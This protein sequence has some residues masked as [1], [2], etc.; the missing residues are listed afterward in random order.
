MIRVD[1]TPNGFPHNWSIS[2]PGPNCDVAIATA[3]TGPTESFFTISD[4]PAGSYQ[5]C[6]VAA[7]CTMAPVPFEVEELE[8]L[9]LEASGVQHVLCFGEATGSVMLTAS[10][11][12][13]P[14]TIT[15]GSDPVNGNTATYGDLPAGTYFY[16]V[17]DSKGCS[18]SIPVT[19]NQPNLIFY[20]QL[21]LQNALCA[22]SA[23]GSIA[24]RP[25]GG[26]GSY[27]VQWRPLGG[28]YTLIALSGGQ[29][30]LSDIGAGSYQ[31]SIED[32]NNCRQEFTFSISEP[33]ALDLVLSDTTHISCFGADD[34][35][36][37]ANGSGGTGDLSYAIDGGSFGSNPLFTN[38]SPGIHTMHVRDENNCELTRNFIILEPTPL[39]GAVDVVNVQCYGADN[40]TITINATGGTAPYRYRLGPAISQVSNVFDGLAPDLYDLVI[41]DANGCTFPINNVLVDEPD[42]LM[43]STVQLTE[44]TCQSGGSAMVSYSGGTPPYS[45][46]WDQDTTIDMDVA[47]D[48]A[49]GLHTVV[50]TDAQGCVIQDEIEITTL[51]VP[52]I[53]IVEIESP[54]C[55]EDN[56]SI[57]ID[58]RGNTLTPFTYTID[59]D[60]MPDGNFTDL[61]AGS[62]L[63]GVSDNLGCMSERTVVV[64]PAPLPTLEVVNMIPEACGQGDGEVT[65]SPVGGESPYQLVMNGSELSG[66]TIT[67]L[68]YG[69]HTV[70][71]T[72]NKECTSDFTFMVDSVRMPTATISSLGEG[73]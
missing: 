49:A 64:P 72:D 18:V 28:D 40:G 17:T 60:T 47:T 4:L 15:D 38:I 20:D 59:G 9:K 35:S 62:Y 68:G 43:I 41:T 70:T 26:N 27:T 24:F 14:Y 19:I 66:L 46:V 25:I 53:H 7:N 48:L 55:D 23:S 31:F 58:V 73:M 63:I 29:V 21:F 36:I 52:I 11:G 56:G 1:F 37:L 34:G 13:P 57:Q 45:V 39:Q 44:A 33:V 6:A 51:G 32:A 16:Q 69:E 67:G 54:D 61:A 10:G 30:I 2:T 50:V 22:D 8:A 5:I 3:S 65:L 12:V 71:I 42:S